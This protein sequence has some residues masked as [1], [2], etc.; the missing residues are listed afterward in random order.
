MPTHLW[1][2]TTSRI[3]VSEMRT[4]VLQVGLLRLDHR[5]T[6]ARRK[7][8]KKAQSA[9]SAMRICSALMSGCW[10]FAKPHAGTR[11]IKSALDNVRQ[12]TAR[13]MEALSSFTTFFFFRCL[14][15][16]TKGADLTCPYCRAKWPSA[17]APA[18]PSGNPFALFAEDRY[19]NLASAVGLSPQRDTSTCEC[20][21]DLFVHHFSK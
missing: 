19:M 3:R 14:G 20:F 12:T 17:T 10:C 18:R 15:K 5:A 4:N 1:P 2:R 16:K 13:V 7:A 21:I 11:C 9:P 8:S 6:T